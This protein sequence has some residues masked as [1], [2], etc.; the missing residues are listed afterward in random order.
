MNQQPPQAPPLTQEM[1]KNAQDLKCDNCGGVL[2]SEKLTFK[3]I[4]AILS[5]TGKEELVPMPVVVCE[6]CGLVSDIFDPNGLVPKVLKAKPD[7]PEVPKM[8]VVS[9]K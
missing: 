5:P 8:E 6:E 2:F 9:K 3:K 1:V 7:K 4:S